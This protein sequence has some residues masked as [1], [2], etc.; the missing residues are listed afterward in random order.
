MSGIADSP[1][2]VL[3]ED[4][5]AER[6]RRQGRQQKSVAGMIEFFS[7]S[8]LCYHISV[9]LRFG[10]MTETRGRNG[11]ASNGTSWMRGTHIKDYPHGE[12]AA[13]EYSLG[14]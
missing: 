14:P 11:G 4:C 9:T 8:V 7:S 12:L 6:D 10:Q 5:T 13:R 1:P 3:G 2:L